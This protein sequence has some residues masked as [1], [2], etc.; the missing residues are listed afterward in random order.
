MNFIIKYIIHSKAL[1]EA[2]FMERYFIEIFIKLIIYI[3]LYIINHI[4]N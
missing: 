4:K 2:S 3:I 1:A